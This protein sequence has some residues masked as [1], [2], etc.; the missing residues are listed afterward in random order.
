[1][2]INFT[3]AAFKHKHF[4]GTHQNVKTNAHKI[5][6]LMIFLLLEHTHFQL[7]YESV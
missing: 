4:H 7:V 1:M 5:T 6:R 2:A 3:H